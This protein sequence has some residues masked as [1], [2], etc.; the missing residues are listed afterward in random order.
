MMAFMGKQIPL[1]GEL[2]TKPDGKACTPAAIRKYLGAKIKD[3]LEPSRAAMIALAGLLPPLA[4]DEALEGSMIHSLAGLL[5][6]GGLVRARPLR[7][8]HQARRRPRWSAPGRARPSE[9]SVPHLGVLFLDEHH[10]E[11]ACP[12]LLLKDLPEFGGIYSRPL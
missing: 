11:I 9:V 1:C 2:A 7:S 4:A 12:P 6:A 8:P 10:M 5:D 3:G